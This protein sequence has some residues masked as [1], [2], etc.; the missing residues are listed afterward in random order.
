V[1]G[2]QFGFQK[3][4]AAI[5][6][7][8]QVPGWCSVEKMRFMQEQIR[9]IA[10]RVPPTGKHFEILDLG[11]WKGRSA[12]ALANALGNHTPSFVWCVDHWLGAPAERET[13]HIQAGIRPLSVLWEFNQYMSHLGLLGKKI[14]YLSMPTPDAVQYFDDEQFHFMFIDAD[15][16]NMY[17]DAKLYLPKLIPGGVAV[18]DDLNWQLV[19]RDWDRLVEELAGKFEFSEH[20]ENGPIGRMLKLSNG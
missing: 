2:K 15:H 13:N 11:S 1:N 18:L 19:R 3:E 6:S 7:Y 20:N 8:E 12:G 16:E 4:L 14:G 5:T 9:E 10:Q 17:R